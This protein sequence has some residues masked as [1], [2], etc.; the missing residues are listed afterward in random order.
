LTA[1]LKR[2]G[3]GIQDNHSSSLLGNHGRR[4]PSES[5]EDEMIET[6][7]KEIHESD[8]DIDYF[9]DEDGDGSSMV[10]SLGII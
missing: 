3:H 9:V 5:K 2:G 6:A 1:I 8:F 4:Y 7:M 10:C